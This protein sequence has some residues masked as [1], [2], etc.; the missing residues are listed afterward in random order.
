MP[1]TLE[2]V[3]KTV[4]D[5]TAKVDALDKPDLSK[6]KSAEDRRNEA[7]SADTDAAELSLNSDRAAATPMRTGRYKRWIRS[8]LKSLGYQPGN[9]KSFGAFIQ[10]GMRR[11]NSA[12][13]SAVGDS[14]AKSLSIKAGDIAKTVQG[15]SE[16]VGSDGGVLVLP[17]YSSNIFDRVYSNDLFAQTDNYTVTGNSMTFHANKETSRANGSRHGGL[18]GYWVGEGATITDS[19]PG[20]RELMLK[21]KKLAIVVY[22]TDELLEDA[23]ALEQYVTRKAA[24]E[25]EF[26]IGDAIFNG[27]GGGQPLGIGL[28]PALLSIAKESGQPADTL[29]FENVNK[30]WARMYGPSRDVAKWYMNQDVEPQ[31]DLMSLGVGTGGAPVYLPQGGVAVAPFRTLKNRPIQET[32]FNATLGDQLDIVLADLSQYVTISKGGIAQAVSM[33]VEFLTAQTALRFIIRV[34]GQTWENSPI[35]PFKGSNTQSSF[36]TLDARA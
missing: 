5:L 28:S 10:D 3:T 27:V 1:A 9:F 16:A 15:M 31:L 23:A 21:L 22:L 12:M 34:D 30:M 25:F 18:R 11:G 33:H 19:K 2:D 8:N 4:A 32:E 14:L 17:E 13:E 6:V 36:V 24:E 20:F 29:Q 35:T 26:L 7:W